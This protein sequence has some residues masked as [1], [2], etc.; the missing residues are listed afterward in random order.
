MKSMKIINS[1]INV[2]LF[3]V[4]CLMILVVLISKA[5]GGEPSLFG[6]ELKIVLSGSMEP[7][8]KTGSV[9]AVKS[10]VNTSELQA[11]DVITY[12]KDEYT[13]VTHRIMDVIETGAGT[14]FQTKGDHNA[15]PDVELVLDQN[16]VAQYTGFTI[17]YVGYVMNFASTKVGILLLLVLPG[18]LLLGYSIITITQALRYL[19]KKIEHPTK[20][21]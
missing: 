10:D 16:V 18:V 4:F 19:D 12:L 11:G 14:L 15:A 20:T 7:E 6:Y 5:S 8:F 3:T 21:M 1:A 2:L 13:L 17:P 9:I